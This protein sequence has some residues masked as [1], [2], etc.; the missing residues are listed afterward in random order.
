MCVC[1]CVGRGGHQSGERFWGR[2][3]VSVSVQCAQ[4][5][6]GTCTLPRNHCSPTRVCPVALPEPHPSLTLVAPTT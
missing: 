4:L 5:P 2:A 3:G 6:L 1:V